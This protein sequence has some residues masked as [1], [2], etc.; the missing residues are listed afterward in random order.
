ME[1]TVTSRMWLQGYATPLVCSPW[2]GGIMGTSCFTTYGDDIV[3][4]PSS[5]PMA[6]AHH[7]SSGTDLVGRRAAQEE[8]DIDMGDVKE[9][10]EEQSTR[11]KTSTGKRK[12]RA[13]SKDSG[14]KEDDKCEGQGSNSA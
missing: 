2:K 6:R 4:G 7:L 10:Q 8:E 3:A 9:E 11:R 12:K 13:M 5:Q 14:D 1:E